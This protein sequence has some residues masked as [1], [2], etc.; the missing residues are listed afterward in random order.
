MRYTIDT[1]GEQAQSWGNTLRRAEERGEIQIIEKGDPIEE[2]KDA[3]RKI[4]RAMEVLKKSG[5]SEEIMVAYMRAKGIAKTHI[6]NVLYHQK[7]FFK[8]LGVYKWIKLLRQK[9]RD[10]E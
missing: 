8:K 10:R 3:V 1:M 9:I 2:V 7:E 4:Q 6:E 5:I